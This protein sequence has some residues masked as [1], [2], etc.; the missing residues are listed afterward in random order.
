MS[1]IVATFVCTTQ[2]PATRGFACCA[3]TLRHPEE[4]KQSRAKRDAN[5]ERVYH[6]ASRAKARYVGNFA[7]ILASYN[8]KL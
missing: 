6:V 3:R 2:N 8:E 5:R 4:P 7:R 1:S